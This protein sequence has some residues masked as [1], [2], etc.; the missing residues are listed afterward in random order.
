M[1]ISLLGISY[2]NIQIST[3][4]HGYSNHII[5]YLPTIIQIKQKIILLIIM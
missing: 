5:Y 3:I 4:Q 1:K 2:T